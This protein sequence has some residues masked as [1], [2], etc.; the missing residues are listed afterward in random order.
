ME[1]KH[2]RVTLA[3]AERV[4]S[5]SP[6]EAGEQCTREKNSSLLKASAAN[7][8]HKIRLCLRR[9]RKQSQMTKTEKPKNTSLA[10]QNPF[11]RHRWLHGTKRLD[12]L[13]F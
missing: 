7:S 4:A 8:K 3:P 10:R 13:D 1:R 5:G 11:Y 12:L 6:P 9:S 2:I